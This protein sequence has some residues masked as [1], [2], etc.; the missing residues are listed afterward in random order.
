MKTK[1]L[2]GLFFII[3]S[4][5]CTT[6]SWSAGFF[7]YLQSAKTAGTAGS[8]A[9]VGEYD[10]S[11]IFYNP[12]GLPKTDNIEF[13]LSTP[14][15]KPS[16]KFKNNNTLNPLGMPVSGNNK[17]KEDVF[18]SPNMALIAKYNEKTTLGIGIYIPFGQIREYDSNWVGRYHAI[19]SDLKTISINPS[20]R[21]DVNESISLGAAI[22]FDY[23]DLTLDSAIDFG[24]LC[25]A[26]SGLGL[27]GCSSIGLAPMAADGK[28][29]LSGDDW[30]VGFTLGLLL[31]PS[32][33]LS[34]GLA[35]RSRIEHELD[36]TAK[37]DV[38]PEAL[39]LT[40]GGTFTKSKISMDMSIPDVFSIGLSY[41]LNEKINLYADSSF[42]RW[43]RFDKSVINYSNPAQPTVSLIHDWEDVWRFAVGSEYKLSSTSYIAFGISHDESPIPTNNIGAILPESDSWMF[44]VGY[45][46]NIT[47]NFSFDIAYVKYV[48]DDFDVSNY[49]PESGLLSGEY[50]LGNDALGVQLN[51]SF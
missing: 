46:R 2:A 6:N 42:T 23:T 17:A 32:S 48:F 7:N 15:G 39:P 4:L 29:S 26:Q 50:E 12:A 16:V 10:A 49:S 13:L 24:A 37:Y 35:Y 1:S 44:S 43:S 28:Q 22:Q 34:I 27:G 36:G 14:I 25:V 5:S 33:D 20:I 38:P 31:K 19:K 30:G 3:A 9:T 51:W 21:Y 11:A 40:A 8:L 45:G 47:D 41:K 18:Y